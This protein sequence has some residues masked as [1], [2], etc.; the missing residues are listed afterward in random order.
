M[1]RSVLVSNACGKRR[2]L[3]LEH[4]A[5]LAQLHQRR[6]RSILFGFFLEAHTLHADGSAGRKPFIMHRI[7]QCV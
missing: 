2:M 4:L 6:I 1:Q 7:S 3:A 5:K